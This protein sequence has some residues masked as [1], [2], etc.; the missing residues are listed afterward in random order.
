MTLATDFAAFINAGSPA[1]TT[2]SSLRTPAWIRQRCAAG[3][4]EFHRAKAQW[5][6]WA[7]DP[8]IAENL[9]YAHGVQDVR[10]YV[11]FNG[12]SAP[13]A[14]SLEITNRDGY[15]DADG[16]YNR[17]SRGSA[18]PAG[19]DPTGL[20]SIINAD[21]LPILPVKLRGLKA[22]V[23]AA[24]YEATIT[25]LGKKA[26]SEYAEHAALLREWM[27]MVQAYAQMGVPQPTK[28]PDPLPQTEEEYKTYLD[29]YQVEAA[30]DLERK[31]QICGIESGIDQLMSELAD[32]L[33]FQGYG[34]L[35][36]EQ[37][38]PRRPVGKRILPSLGLFL[39]SAFA[40]Y[41]DRDEGGYLQY[42][43]Y[44][45]LLSEVEADVD[46]TCNSDGKP[47]TDDDRAI[48]KQ[49]ADQALP[50]GMQLDPSLGIVSGSGT[51]LVVR[52]KFRADDVR[53]WK[54]KTDEAGNQRTRAIKDPK[55]TLVGKGKL[56]EV[57]VNN[58]YE[59][60][61]VAGTS[62][63]FSCR[64]V[65]DQG[66]DLHN[67]LKA[68]LPFSLYAIT[69]NGRPMS[70]TRNAKGIVDEIERSWR[71]YMA[72]K[73]TYTPTGT[74]IPPDMLTLMAESMKFTD[75][76]AAYEFIKRTGDSFFPRNDNNNPGQPV[77]SPI[78]TNPFGIPE[79]AVKHLSDM[80]QQLQLLEMVTG[81]NAVVSATIPKGDQGKGVNQ[82]A[83]QGA[84]NVMAFLRDGLKNIYEN[85]ARNI[86]GRIWL[87]EHENPVTGTVPGDG[88]R[89]R[90]VGP[91]KQL[92]DYEFHMD[93]RF[94]P[95]ADEWQQLYAK[96]SQASAAGQITIADE[97]KIQWLNNLKTAQ[98][99]LAMAVARKAREDDARQAKLQEQNGQVQTQS[100]QAAA[101]SQQA[102][103]DA[104]HKNKMEQLAF[105]RDTTWGGIDR[106]TSAQL[107][108]ARDSNV[109]KQD[110]AITNQHGTLTA[111]Q[112][113]Q[114]HE[115]SA[116]IRDSL[117]LPENQ[118]TPGQSAMLQQLDQGQSQ[119]PQPPQM[120]QQMQPPM[121]DP[122]MQDP[123]MQDPAQMGDPSQMPQPESSEPPLM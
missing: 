53:R 58:L 83:L 31:V 108:I 91:N 105:E 55:Y 84:A 9:R 86:A 28:L 94:S 98:R 33:L 90:Y 110:V 106:T 121:G 35:I 80:F 60:T 87:S 112:Q 26:D 120:P 1:A 49:L 32:D 18:S 119:P 6:M 25:A 67:P 82:I 101:Q 71:G 76:N 113:Q 107:Q 11:R 5:P 36:D 93:V 122:A 15:F 78:T 59:A 41:R 10:Q 3:L 79:E 51:L 42:L 95:T 13:A 20:D 75:E 89:Q 44:A 73:R 38:G 72:V 17:A 97:M 37:L 96:A 30:A 22:T 40:D 69:A 61:L 48:I 23:M 111:Q 56:L 2:D 19:S 4:T 68:R 65:Y 74:N 16:G 12:S 92:A 7:H 66:R 85:H 8:D 102:A 45:D 21:P 47:W 123:M 100:A 99:Y 116:A 118:G 52:W 81:A 50:V 29:D 43:S 39:P 14:N 54:T 62:L 115:H 63:A 46:C 64:K 34:C 88:G 109:T 104:A 57:P 77:V 24:G 114:E 27:D 103:N 70:V 117:L